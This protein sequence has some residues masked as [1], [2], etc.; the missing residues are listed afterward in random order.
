M[1]SETTPVDAFFADHENHI[2][3]VARQRFVLEQHG[4]E[5]DAYDGTTVILTPVFPPF[6]T[7]KE[8][9]EALDEAKRENARL[10][11]A[12]R[13]ITRMAIVRN[14][15]E[16]GG[17]LGLVARGE[18]F[19]TGWLERSYIGGPTESVRRP[20]GLIDQVRGHTSTR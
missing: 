9:V 5:P 18:L 2:A 16:D 3:T 7:Q 12:A 15:A 10:T 20:G 4:E 17:L 8:R 11:T 6:P 14:R 1:T 19:I 13:S